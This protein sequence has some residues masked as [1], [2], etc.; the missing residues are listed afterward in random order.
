[1]PR[2]AR[3]SLFAAAAVAALFLGA[4]IAL[5][6]TGDPSAGHAVAA[7]PAA[8]ATAVGARL[9]ECDRTMRTDDELTRCHSHV[10]REVIVPYRDSPRR[11]SAVALATRTLSPQVRAV[12]H[13]AMHDVGRRYA[14]R[15]RVTLAD[16][17]S[18]LPASGDTGCPAGF[19]HG[20]LMTLT[21]ALHQ[22][23]PAA[24]LALCRERPSRLQ[25]ITCRHGIGHAF[26]RLANGNVSRA[27][28]E[29]RRL[30][31]ATGE[32]A[33]GVFHD[34]WL[35]RRGMDDAPQAAAPLSPR[36]LC[37]AQRGVAIEVCWYP[38]FIESDV[39]PVVT[40]PRDAMAECAGLGARHERACLAGLVRALDPSPF[41]QLAIC[42]DLPTENAQQGCV[43]G[44]AVIA[45]GAAPVD[46]SL[47]LL[48]GCASMLRPAACA[49]SVARRAAIAT[50]GRFRPGACARAGNQ[51]TA[52]R[53][54]LRE[55]DRPFYTLA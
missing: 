53:Q 3:L 9:E 8:L 34:Y 31:P 35:A 6:R 39:R 18:V 44:V 41:V 14:E 17:Q 26:S 55:T 33:Q 12:C 19:A 52:C 7:T 2:F 51:A 45:L 20:V 10:W 25:E 29:C 28:T 36:E 32:C 30:G 43:E 37:Q 4:I 47:S 11:L 5:T 1:M 24:L 40:G 49:R 27:L 13:G 22:A 46:E 21:G 16:L 15:H 38:V 50:E 54:G 42:A 48:A 23:R